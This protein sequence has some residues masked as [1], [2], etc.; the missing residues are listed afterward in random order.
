MKRKQLLLLLALLITVA[1]GAWAQ[2]TL[3]V[4]DGTG[5]QTTSPASIVYCNEYARSQTIIPSTALTAMKGC[6]ITAM[7]FYSGYGNPF[8]TE[9]SFDVYLKEVSYSA[10]T[11]PYT[12]EP[13]SSCTTVYQGT[14]SVVNGT[15]TLTVTFSKPFHYKGGNLLI[16]AEN[17]SMNS[18][19]PYVEFQGTN[20]NQD[21]TN[22][23]IHHSTNLASATTIA[24]SSFIPKTTFT[25]V[26]PTYTVNVNDGELNPTTWKAKV[27]DATEFGKLPLE[28]VTEGQTVTLQYNGQ[29][30]VRKVTA[31]M[32]AKP[33]AWDGDLA[34]LT[35][36]STEEF[37]TATNGMTITGTLTANVKVS[38]ADG[39]TVTLDGATINGVNNESY[40][41][42]G[43]NCLGNA[44]IILKDD[45]E[46]TVTGFYE[47]YP[48]IHVPS[49][50][51]LTILGTGSLT[52]SSNGWGAGIGGGFEISCGDISIEGG[53]ITA[54]GGDFSA[55]IG[56][57][58]CNIGNDATCGNITITN[59]VTRVTA[60]KGE[61]APYSIGAGDEAKC[62]TVTIGGTVYW[63]SNAAVDEPA[64]TYLATSPLTLNN[65][66]GL[67][68]NCEEGQRW[69]TI[70]SNNSDKLEENGYYIERKDNH[71]RLYNADTYSEI[72]SGD[73]Y[74]SNNSYV[75]DI[76]E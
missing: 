51:K 4:Y 35:A 43:I 46:N 38:I 41:W 66:A 27:G 56:G 2:Q 3:T 23:S 55:G 40:K 57:G 11:D 1:T 44:T 31:T 76:L 29:R 15:L 59:G 45:T 36:E 42:A 33:V 67:L 25:Y 20:T 8:T 21:Y 37:A 64:A 53:I 16:G 73:S 60:T 75:W 48:G 9:C 74:S 30:R 39:A 49:G 13:Q 71:Y 32:D 26:V 10:F 50:K 22:I 68:L 19:Y 54:T 14:L 52:A 17:T 65:V 70:I 61:D 69:S 7:T 72:M 24:K 58:T 28:N 12:F 47:E 63:Q 34:K 6:D 62:G 5:R 18:Y